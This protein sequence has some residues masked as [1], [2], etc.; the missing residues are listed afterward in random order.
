MRQM[1]TPT[2]SSIRNKANNKTPTTQ[3][4]QTGHIKNIGK[5][6]KPAREKNTAVWPS[7]RTHQNFE[8]ATCYGTRIDRSAV[9]T[10]NDENIPSLIDSNT[11]NMTRNKTHVT[12]Y[13]LAER[14][15][16]RS[17]TRKPIRYRTKA[18]RPSLRTHQN[19]EA[20]THYKTRID[21]NVVRTKHTGYIPTLIDS[22]IENKT[23]DKT[24]AAQYQITEHIKN[25]GKTRK[26]TRYQ[27]NAVRPSLRTH[28]NFEA[29][30][31]YE[32]RI[33]RK[34]SRT[35]IVTLS[36]LHLTAV[37]T[38]TPRGP[39]P[40]NSTHS[41]PSSPTDKMDS[42]KKTNSNIPSTTKH[43]MDSSKTKSES[44]EQHVR[45]KYESIP[46]KYKFH[47]GHKVQ[48]HKSHKGHKVR[49]SCS[50]Q[51][52]PK[53]KFHK[54]HKV[55]ISCSRHVTSSKEYGDHAT[56]A[57]TLSRTLSHLH[58]HACHYAT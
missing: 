49:I 51:V 33:Y 28:Q 39:R 8:A 36:N 37:K 57:S 6:R 45:P 23:H 32:T 12:Q 38:N 14:I 41:V 31:H 17:K 30:T 10:E 5:A 56:A 29:T 7:L 27:S 35:K 16:N 4:Q 19:F 22:S 58:L 9:K 52:T 18:V 26:P 53:Y 21:G 40:N 20:T 25:R 46:T 54:G 44:R 48:I 3:Y 55:R 43:K 50:R 2:I 11:E 15:K 13:Q 34:V 1:S 24:P 47:K 42:S